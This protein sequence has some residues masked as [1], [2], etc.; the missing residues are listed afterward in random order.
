MFMETS[1]LIAFLKKNTN[2]MIVIY[3]KTV[4]YSIMSFALVQELLRLFV[5]HYLEKLV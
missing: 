5:I 1:I 2:S 4:S 3:S